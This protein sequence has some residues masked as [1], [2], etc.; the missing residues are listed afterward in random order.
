MWMKPLPESSLIQ[1]MQQPS[2][3]DHP[4]EQVK[5]IE[6]HI[7]W[8]FLAGE[9]AYKVKKPVD[10]GFLNFS[11][12]AKRRHFC[13]EELRLNRR[14][15]PHLYLD[16]KTIGGDPASP[17]IGGQPPLEYAVQMRRF[18]QEDQLDRMLP[19]GRLTV[20]KLTHFATM[21][22]GF[23]QAAPVAD[24]GQPYGAV[25]SIIEPVLENFSQITPL[26][27]A[28]ELGPLS[29]LEEWSRNSC[30]DLYEL[31]RQRKEDGFI[32]ECHGDLH[33][34]NMA[35]IDDG[36]TLFDC[37]E[38]NANLRW[39][40]VMSD[41]AFLVMDLD[42]RGETERGWRF[43]NRYLQETG[44]YSG[45]KLLRFYELYRAMVRAKVT[46]M[47]LAQPDLSEKER[48][49]DL[50][51]YHSYLDLAK[52]YIARPSRRLIITH[53]LSGSGKSSFVRELAAVCGG[54]H[55][56]SDR[57]RKRIYDL[58]AAADSQSTVGGGIYSKQA[59][60]ATYERLRL[61][62]EMVISA[63]Y[64]AIVDA[65]FLKKTD[66]DRLRRSAAELQI[67]LVILD[68]PVA[69][70]ELRRRVQQRAIEGDDVSDAD[71][72]VLN[73]QLATQRPLAE[74]ERQRVITV[75]PDTTPAEVA[76]RIIALAD[77]KGPTP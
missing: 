47:R 45:L 20:D 39:I 58:P 17:K 19:T 5:R 12:L 36:P 69:E 54:V 74:D 37:I 8:V 23:H 32:R 1:A 24:T 68:F 61:L 49:E 16:V 50:A 67:P 25:Q 22:A 51:L 33:L 28:A 15:A 75:S 65:T 76:A 43:L 10:F 29:E 6:T 2:F 21:I 44:D 60:A 3:Y 27:P 11:T 48:R 18:A 30:H 46:C 62:A 64:P 70:A 35:W 63:G 14:F 34:A 38:F 55:L 52:S 26:L 4:V 9:F 42:D 40:D 13:L 31:L 77:R 73:R 72:E 57:E 66:R 53:G 71:I 7:S 56:Q 41:I 59:N